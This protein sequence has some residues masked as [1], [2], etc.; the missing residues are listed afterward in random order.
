M[1]LRGQIGFMQ[2]KGFEVIGITSPG[3]EVKKIESRENIRVHTLKMTRHISPH[4]DLFALLEMVRILCKIKPTI[5]N[6]STPK[7]GM[8]AIFAARLTRIPV[9]IYTLRGLPYVTKRGIKRALLLFIERIVCKLS[10]KI[11]TT[12]FSTKRIVLENNLSCKNKTTISGYGTGN[13]IDYKNTFNPRLISIDMRNNIR[14][15]Y[16]IPKSAIVI[17]FVGRI[18]VEKGIEELAEAWELLK[19]HMPFIYLMI[20]GKEEKEDQVSNDIL[21]KLKNDKSVVFTG[22]QK[23]MAQF[24]A[25]I[26]INVLPS[27]REGIGLTPLEAGAMEKPSVVTD[28]DG[29]CETVIHQKT[30][31]KVSVKNS[32]ELFEGIRFLYENREIAKNYGKAARQMVKERFRPEM[33]WNELYRH[34]SLLLEER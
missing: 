9:V 11:I 20:I 14:K 23:K 7:G 21:G 32:T 24:Y 27:H 1:F 4:K 15:Q 30:G 5:I 18:V 34:Y 28:I 22:M 3:P 16:G 26:D 19:L 10:D 8:L 2:K 6:A 13:G 17:G 31:I 33:I 12:S 29:L 25:A